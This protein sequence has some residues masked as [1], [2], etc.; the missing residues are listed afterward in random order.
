[1]TFYSSVINKTPY[2]GMEDTDFTP[3]ISFTVLLIL[4]SP[5]NLKCRKESED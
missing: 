5:I 4:L 3:V 1:M 2:N